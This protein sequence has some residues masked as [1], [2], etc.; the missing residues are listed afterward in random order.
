M[1][2]LRLSICVVTYESKGVVEKF[3]SELLDS[4]GGCCNWEVLYYDNSKSKEIYNLINASKTKGVHIIHDPRNL[5]FSYANNQ[6]ILRSKYNNIL[7]LNPDVFGLTQSF[8]SIL[9]SQF[10]PGTVSF[11]RLLNP[12]GSFQ[13][14]I[15]KVSSLSRAFFS[16][17]T[18]YSKISNNEIIEMGIMAFMLTDKDVF[19]KV[20]LLDCD[21]PLYAEDMDW[22]YRATK[23][24]INLIYNPKLELTHIGGA[25]SANRWHSK[26]IQLK[27]YAAE[28]IFV[29][30][31]Y[32]GFNQMAMFFLNAIKCIKCKWF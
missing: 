24:D 8:W 31:H 12:D 20:G 16:D 10:S 15:G 23:A 14:C 26:K 4:L 21:Y 1:F 18:D 11:I 19:S 28:R 2:D 27:K 25:S 32:S 13:N 7:L 6:L 29:R 9:L 30:K 5:G 17:E 3:H 22:C